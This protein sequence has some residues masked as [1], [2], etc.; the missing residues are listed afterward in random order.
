MHRNFRFAIIAAAAIVS[1]SAASAQQRTVRHVD[2]VYSDLNLAS[3]DGRAE[4]DARIAAAAR[5]ACGGAPAFS[6]SFRDASQFH[7]KAYEE[8]RAEALRDAYAVLNSRGVHVA[9]R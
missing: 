1:A 8:C 5:R 2:V 6:A 3:R 9:A 4:L 7:K